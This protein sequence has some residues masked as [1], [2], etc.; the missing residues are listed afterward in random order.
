MST[1]SSINTV[2][3]SFYELMDIASAATDAQSGAQGGAG[4]GTFMAAMKDATSVLGCQ[5]V[6]QQLDC[7]VVAILSHYSSSSRICH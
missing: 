7:S 5:Q 2:D 3:W 4:F 1:R 6:Q